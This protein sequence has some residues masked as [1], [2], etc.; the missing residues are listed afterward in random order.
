MINNGLAHKHNPSTTPLWV[1]TLIFTGTTNRK[2]KP[3]FD[4]RQL[5][6]K[7]VKKNYLEP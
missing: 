4:Y 1:A 5:K 6:T 7:T 3:Y 2:L